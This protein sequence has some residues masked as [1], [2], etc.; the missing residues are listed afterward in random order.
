MEAGVAEKKIFIRPNFISAPTWN[1]SQQGEG[2]YVVF[3]GRLSKEKGV[4]TLLR[5]FEKLPDVKLKIVGSGGIED[6]LKAYVQQK[7]LRN[8][9]FLGHKSGDEKWAVL[10]G[11][12]FAVV[13]SEWYENFPISVL[14]HYAA[15]KPVIA[16]RIGGL[17]YIVEDG[18]TGYLHEAGNADD[19]ASKVRQMLSDPGHA[20]KMGRIGRELVETRY[21]AEQGYTNLMNI[22]SK[23]VAH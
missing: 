6:E 10:R 18:K 23:V 17:P 12:L 5:A 4:H 11:A 13:P 1:S 7:G 20:A 2:D 21:G 14:E 8:I 19:L 3:L 22:F 9:E 16:S 15:S